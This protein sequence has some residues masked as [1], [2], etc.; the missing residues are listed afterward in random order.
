MRI[1]FT[2]SDN[3]AQVTESGT[4]RMCH[5]LDFATSGVLACAKSSAAAR[6]VSSLFEARKARKL[7]AAL[8]FGHPEWT[9]RD[10]K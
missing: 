2:V 1:G 9:T 7:Y 8:V 4:T 5:N 6:E 3:N 10:I